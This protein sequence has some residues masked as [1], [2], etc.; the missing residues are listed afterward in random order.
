[1]EEKVYICCWNQSRDGFTLWLKS[2]PKIRAAGANYSEAEEKLIE[3][4]QDSGGAMVPT[5][6]FDSPLPKSTYE[7]KYCDPEL[8]IIGGADGFETDAPRRKPQET[9]GDQNDRLKWRD[10]FFRLP[11]CRNCKYESSPR[12]DK[13]LTLNA[14]PASCDGA[15]GSVGRENGATIQIFS[16]EFLKRLTPNEHKRLKFKPVNWKGR[17]K[18]YELVG[19]AGLPL[20]GV[21]G[22]KPSGWRCTKCRYRSWGYWM[23]GLAI[24][25]FIAK[26]DLPR[27][28]SGIFTIGTLPEISLVATAARWQELVGKKGTRG[29]VSEMLGVV[30]DRE[31]VRQPKLSVRTAR[32]SSES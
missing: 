8:F 3:M 13:P 24:H 14:I 16:E 20:V 32:P 31:V 19:P 28:M 1:M 4:I 29:I 11:V 25:T 18:F 7:A 9:V 30:S 6:E 10:E 23:E 26:A 2:R 21:A 17:R 22:L 15:F 12:S 5:F 27:K